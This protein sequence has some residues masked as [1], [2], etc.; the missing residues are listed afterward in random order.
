MPDCPEIEMCS[1]SNRSVDSSVIS[2]LAILMILVRLQQKGE[3]NGLHVLRACTFALTS[4]SKL[5]NSLHTVESARNSGVTK[6]ARPTDIR[7]FHPFRGRLGKK[8]AMPSVLAGTIH[9]PGVLCH[10][11]Y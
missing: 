11:L 5:L 2:W 3:G 4:L 1:I 10:P 8:T 6:F 7:R 9:G